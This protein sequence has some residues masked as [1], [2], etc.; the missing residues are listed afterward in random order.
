MTPERVWTTWRRKILASAFVRWYQMFA[1]FV[2]P[3]LRSLNRPGRNYRM[4][5]RKVNTMQRQN[6]IKWENDDYV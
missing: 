6:V 1:I 2:W 4:N 3:S 5:C